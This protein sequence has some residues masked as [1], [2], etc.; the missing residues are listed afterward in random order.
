MQRCCVVAA[1]PRQQ[2][3]Q[4]QQQQPRQQRLLDLPPE[5]VVSAAAKRLNL[6]LIEFIRLT[7]D[8]TQ[9]EHYHCCSL[10]LSCRLS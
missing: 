8:E 2:Q 7:V 1:P 3:Q 5:P 4:Q 10:H 9:E 6:H